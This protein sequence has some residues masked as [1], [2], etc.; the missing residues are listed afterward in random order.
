MAVLINKDGSVLAISKNINQLLSPIEVG[1]FEVCQQAKDIINNGINED[2]VN[3]LFDF[4]PKEM[5]QICTI[6]NLMPTRASVFQRQ[7][8]ENNTRSSASEIPHINEGNEIHF[9][10]AGSYIIYF[11]IHDHHY[12]LI[13]QEGDWLYIPADVEH[14]IKATDDSYLVIASYHNE[15]FDVFHSKVKYTDTKSMAFIGS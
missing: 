3:D 12:S 13:V 14:W 4:I 1:R 5:H 15:P 6:R 11:N 7:E 8:G 9:F 10:F 2:N